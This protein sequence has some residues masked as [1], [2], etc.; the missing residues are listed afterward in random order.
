MST[1]VGI[2]AASASPDLDA[3]QSLRSDVGTDDGLIVDWSSPGCAGEA[4]RV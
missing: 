1:S 2:L 4:I 3:V